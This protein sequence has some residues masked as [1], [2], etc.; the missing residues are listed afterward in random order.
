MDWQGVGTGWGRGKLGR[1][2]TALSEP[3]GAL[4]GRIKGQKLSSYN[5]RGLTL[6]I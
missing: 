2:V 5:W 4:C 6:N 1:P 3:L